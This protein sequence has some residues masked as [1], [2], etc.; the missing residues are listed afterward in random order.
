[1]SMQC[2]HFQD[3]SREDIVSIREECL[4]VLVTIKQEF[5]LRHSSMSQTADRPATAIAGSQADRAY[6]GLEWLAD[7]FEAIALSTV[8][9]NFHCPI[10]DDQCMPLAPKLYCFLRGVITQYTQCSCTEATHSLPG[11]SDNHPFPP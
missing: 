6:W 9:P 1:M 10:F 11:A 3:A 7:A 4:P 8:T 2:T 5:L